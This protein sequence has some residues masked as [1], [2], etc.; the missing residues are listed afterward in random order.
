MKMPP[1]QANSRQLRCRSSGR[2]EVDR[3]WR[4]FGRPRN[5]PEYA[6]V[7]VTARKFGCD[8][9][10]GLC[11]FWQGW[12]AR[13]RPASWAAGQSRK[14]IEICHPNSLRRGARSRHERRCGCA[15]LR[16]S[17]K[18][19]CQATGFKVTLY[20]A[21]ARQCNSLAA[22]SCVNRRCPLPGSGEVKLD[23]CLGAQSRTAALG[24]KAVSPLSES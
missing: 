13:H 3:R 19:I 7:E 18:R 5:L 12:A 16:G 23:V 24:P 20:K 22:Q 11:Q 6:K 4:S 2:P 17:G 21:S 8:L 15:P 14:S 1:R 9:L 10:D